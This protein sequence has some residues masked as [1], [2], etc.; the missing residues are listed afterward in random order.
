VTLYRFRRFERTDMSMLADWLRTTEVARWWGDPDEELALVT[1]DLDQPLMRQWIVVYENRPF[2]YVQAY[3]VQA[4]PQP[5]LAALPNGTVAVD[6]F[7]GVP[8]MIGRGHGGVFLRLFAEK[9]IEDGAPCVAIDP[10]AD[11]HRARRAYAR[12]GF[13]EAGETETEEGSVVVMVF[14]PRSG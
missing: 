13:I 7:I 10:V 8:D 5:H 4:W 9:L 12:A 11:N 3:P 1:G 6:A 2:A 14:R